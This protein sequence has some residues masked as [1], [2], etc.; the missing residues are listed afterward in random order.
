MFGRSDFG[1]ISQ[2][3]ICSFLLLSTWTLEAGEPFNPQ[4]LSPDFFAETVETF[5]NPLTNAECTGFEQP[6]YCCT[7]P[8]TGTCNQPVSS[9]VLSN[10][11]TRDRDCVGA[12]NPHACCSGNGLGNCCYE[13]SDTAN[14]GL[15]SRYCPASVCPEGCV[16]QW[17][18]Q[19][20]F[21]SNVFSHPITGRTLEQDDLEK[22]C[23][24]TDCLNGHPCLVGH[25]AWTEPGYPAG[26]QPDQ[27]ATME[28]E[29]ADRTGNL[30]SCSGPFYLAQLVKIV[31][32][33]EDHRLLAGL[34]KRL[35]DDNTFQMKAFG[36]SA[37]VSVDNAFPELDKWYFIELQRNSDNTLRLW[38]DGVNKT[39]SPTPVYTSSTVW[40]IHSFCDAKTCDL[41]DNQ[42]FQGEAALLFF[43]CG[44]G[45]SPAEKVL[46]RDYVEDTFTAGIFS[47][48]FET[49][50]A[51]EWDQA[52]VLAVFLDGFE[53]GDVSRWSSASG[54]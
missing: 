46:M 33:T 10:C 20:G 48:D 14:D 35:I 15:G 8:G 45:P 27:D 32:Q 23:Y 1:W 26:E 12:G 9:F 29:G 39:R 13:E 34:T 37:V 43:R 24:K 16:S 52:P 42:E 40:A 53:T 5:T 50:D 17:V 18:E 3:F 28:I 6:N 7:G 31:P 49:G 30:S 54:I 51:S 38:I 19:S 44:I 41:E 36:N 11:N 4:Q 2:L 47:D 25:P 21:K 22:P